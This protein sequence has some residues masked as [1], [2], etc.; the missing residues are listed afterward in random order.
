MMD[1]AKLTIFTLKWSNKYAR[2]PDSII[3]IDM[4]IIKE[5]YNISDEDYAKFL[6]GTQ[7]LGMREYLKRKG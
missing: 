1:K 7:I 6:I 3:N 2:S 4:E 5:K